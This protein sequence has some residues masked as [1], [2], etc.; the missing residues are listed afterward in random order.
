MSRT[1]NRTALAA[2]LGSRLAGL[3]WRDLGL[4]RAE[5]RAG[6]PVAVAAVLVVAADDGVMPQTVE[7]LNHAQAADVPIVVAVNKIDKEGADPAKIRGQMTEYGLIPEEYGGE[8][9]FV[10]ISARNGENIDKLLQH[11]AESL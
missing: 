2:R 5:L 8:T 1:M 6:I 4:S 11:R 9:M 3:A 10:D 7:A